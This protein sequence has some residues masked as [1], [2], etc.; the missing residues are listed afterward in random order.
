M[1]DAALQV[2]TGQVTYAVRDTLIDDKDIKQ[3][4]IMGIGEGRIL[5]V[6]ND[7]EDTA[8]DMVCEMVDE[9]SS[10]VSIYFGEESD[11]EKAASLS[12]R[13]SER[14]PEVEVEVDYGGQPIYYYII[15]VE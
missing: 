13:I 10:L 14:F 15:S 3:G 4:D 5:A 11:E 7:A 2:K 6:G 9:E 12:N 1:K 8:F